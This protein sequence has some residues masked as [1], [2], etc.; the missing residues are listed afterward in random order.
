MLINI[1]TLEYREF[2]LSEEEWEGLMRVEP[3]N[4]KEN[5]LRKFIKE[6]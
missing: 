3:Q 6:N 5:K 2:I 1:S 4:I